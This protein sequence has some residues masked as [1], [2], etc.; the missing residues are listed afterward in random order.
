M[1]VPPHA[2]LVYGVDIFDLGDG[3]C[4]NF[5]HL[6]LDAVN[7]PA[8]YALCRPGEQPQDRDDNREARN[9]V[10]PRLPEGCTYPG[11]HDSQ[12]REGVCPGV[13][14]VGDQ[15][16]RSNRLANS[17]SVTRNQ[18]ISERTNKTRPD[19]PGI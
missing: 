7:E 9:W 16:L 1:A 8:E 3:R 5:E 19:H 15:R 14:S 4:C 2:E 11:C 17:N 13:A 18:L 6:R 12:R 10:D